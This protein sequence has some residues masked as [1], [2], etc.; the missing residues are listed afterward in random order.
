MANDRWD[1]CRLNSRT[2]TFYTSE[3]KR[4]SRVG[5][6]SVAFAQLGDQG[7]E[8]AAVSNDMSGTEGFYFKRR[9]P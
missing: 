3:G 4:E 8:L 1:Y 6:Q 9:R 5:D 7:W 2:V